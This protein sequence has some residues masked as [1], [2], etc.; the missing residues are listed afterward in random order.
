MRGVASPTGRAKAEVFVFVFVVGGRSRR[1]NVG[2]GKIANPVIVGPNR[3]VGDHRYAAAGRQTIQAV[4]HMAAVGLH[5]V[6]AMT[7]NDPA[8][9]RA[10]D[11]PDAEPALDAVD[12]VA[13]RIGEVVLQI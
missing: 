10:P 2:R 6:S 7:L 11:R 4:V 13:D 1:G 9:F 5:V 8:V 12:D 3:L